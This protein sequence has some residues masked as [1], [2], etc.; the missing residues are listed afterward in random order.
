MG[1]GMRASLMILMVWLAVPSLGSGQAL[2]ATPAQQ[3]PC[4]NRT[5]VV[6]ALGPDG[7]PVRGLG[8]ERFRAR[9][10]RRPVVIDSVDYNVGNRRVVVLLDISGSMVGE[11]SKIGS[12]T[13]FIRDLLSA[14]SLPPSFAV[15]TFTDRV[16]DEV[17]FG[18]GRK[19]VGDELAKIDT[20]NWQ[21]R[22]G[23]GKTAWLDAVLEAVHLLE[24]GRL[25]DAI[26]LVTDGEDN[27]SKSRPSEVRQAL[28][29]QGVRLFGLLFLEVGFPS[30]HLDA[31]GYGPEDLKGLVVDSGG[32]F[33]ALFN[34]DVQAML[35]F[36]R[37]LGWEI[38]EFYELHL[39]LPEPLGKPRNWKLEVVD[40]DGEVNRH[41]EI[42][43][44]RKLAACS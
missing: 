2:P 18:Q 40:P 13:G 38:S 6:N 1:L 39:T 44:R 15:L 26:C 24:P 31:E 8:A 27:M 7:S 41:L 16:E 25:G 3:D 19:A 22:R 12:S 33:M 5:V 28:L 23:H 11:K 34:P 43:Y 37:R 21:R 4:L 29:T 10:G 42:A 9:L 20:T 36:S 30:R 32:S 35:P 14:S 17:D